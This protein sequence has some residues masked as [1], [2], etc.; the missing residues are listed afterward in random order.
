MTD[1]GHVLRP[2]RERWAVTRDLVDY[3]GAAWYDRAFDL[4]DG[5]EGSRV[6]MYSAGRREAI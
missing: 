6:R 4:V 3:T 2:G 1:H 5:W